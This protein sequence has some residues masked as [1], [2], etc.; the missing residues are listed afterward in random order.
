MNSSILTGFLK[1]LLM[2]LCV[3]VFM[4]TLYGSAKAQEQ[5]PKP[6]KVEVR[7]S[8]HLSFGT[9]IQAGNYGTVTVSP[10]G[11]RSATGDIILPM[12]SSVITPALFDVK[13]IPG[14]IITIQ[15]IP[16]A[17]LTT[18]NGVTPLTLHFDS[19][20]YQSPFITTGINTEVRIGGT[21]I[22]NSLL[23]NPAGDYSGTF[24]VTFIQE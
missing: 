8:Q 16:D 7:T 14:T 4:I 6:I 24:E 5:P 2:P 13:A 11:V 9:F 22:V 21:L 1:R 17:S 18:S 10:N 19:F 3:L 20:S 12:M 15:P 23:A